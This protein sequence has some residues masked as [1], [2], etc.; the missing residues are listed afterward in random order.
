MIK[1][2]F[3]ILVSIIFLYLLSS[4]PSFNEQNHFVDTYVHNVDNADQFSTSSN[5][6]MLF[7]TRNKLNLIQIS[8]TNSITPTPITL[9]QYKSYAQII[10]EISPKYFDVKSAIKKP[11]KDIVDH[12]FYAL[13]QG[14]GGSLCDSTKYDN[15]K[16]W[17]DEGFASEELELMRGENLIVCGWNVGEVIEIITTDPTGNKTIV[18]QEATRHWELEF[19]EIGYQFET[20]LFDPIGEY[21]IIFKGDKNTISLSVIV[22]RPESPRLYH[23]GDRLVF[24]NFSPNEEFRLFAYSF[25]QIKLVAWQQYYANDDGYLVVIIP[26]TKYMYFAV[27]E[28]TGQERPLWEGWGSWWNPSIETI[29]C[30]GAP[31]HITGLVPFSIVRVISS[32][33]LTRSISGESISIDEG[34]TLKVN[35]GPFCRDNMFWWYVS[36]SSGCDEIG[37][38]VPEGNTTE[39][40]LELVSPTI[41]QREPYYPITNCASSRL[42]LGDTVIL[43]DGIDYVS[44]RN[45]PDTHPSNN[46][47]GRVEPNEYA[48]II[49]GPVC[50]YGWLLWKVS[51][52]DR[53]VGW[54]PETNGT[55]FWL[56]AVE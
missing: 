25:D 13:G 3:T 56:V 7:R 42:Y 31:N 32:Q 26:E 53:I 11:P 6:S 50:N 5:Q 14:G 23:L 2:T 33:I 17:I 55:V 19:G 39:Y 40:F 12:L 38:E 20:D 22:V 54:I 49:D 34:D 8:Q 36:C 1:Q 37:F 29:Y 43:E 16:V 44:I 18:T 35:M 4:F 9:Q 41:I 15:G 48:E 45:E 47:I 51:N 21:S 27:A 52:S 10:A 24:L 28:S 30:D 46:K